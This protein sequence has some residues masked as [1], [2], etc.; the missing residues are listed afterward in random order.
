VKI[1]AWNM[2][3][4]QMRA[5]SDE[6]WRYLIEEL[7]STIALLTEARP[8][9]HLIEDGGVVFADV[10]GRGDWGTAV[11]AVDGIDLRG[12]PVDAS[13]P[14]AIVAAEFDMPGLGVPITAI[15][16]YGLLERLLGTEYSITSLH[17]SLSDLTGVL[18][19]RSR[20]GRII[21]GGDLNASPLRWGVTHRV[22]FDRI[23]S[24]GLE[25]CLDYREQPTP[26]HR[27]VQIDY[28]FV[29]H[30]LVPRG[31]GELRRRCRRPERPPCSRHRG[32][33]RGQTVTRR[34][35]RD[36]RLQGFVPISRIRRFSTHGRRR[37]TSRSGE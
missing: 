3:H 13:H 20:R 27:A 32:R 7:S 26:T 18:E 30:E 31:L 23:E 9:A 19:D 33:V 14:G 21:L 5:R 2:N 16:L 29:S 6:A 15:S 1:V 10:E 25:S 22:L 11:Y 4:W 8:P 34:V 28:V 24:F 36:A 35:P 37:L 12:L 17:R